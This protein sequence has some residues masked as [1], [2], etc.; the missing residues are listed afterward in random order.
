LRSETTLLEIVISQFEYFFR[1]ASAFLPPR[2]VSLQVSSLVDENLLRLLPVASHALIPDL[3]WPSQLP[4][5]AVN[6]PG[7]SSSGSSSP[8]SVPATAPGSGSGSGQ[9]ANGGRGSSSDRPAA[10]P[11]A[12]APGPERPGVR[13]LAQG[14]VGHTNPATGCVDVAES[15]HCPPK[16]PIDPL[17]VAEFDLPVGVGYGG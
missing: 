1:A 10:V 6:S 17:L 16:H 4:P 13:L 11:P 14:P 5:L 9:G 15:I 3:Q 12:P 8:G 7:S 2:C